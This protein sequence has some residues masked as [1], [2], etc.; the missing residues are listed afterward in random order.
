M[1]RFLIFLLLIVPFVSPIKSEKVFS[2][3]EK[4][5]DEIVLLHEEKSFNINLKKSKSNVHTV[6]WQ[7][8]KFSRKATKQNKAK[9]IQ[10]FFDATCDIEQAFDMVM[11]GIKN[12]VDK[13]ES[14]VNS[15]GVNAKLKLDGDKFKIIKEKNGFLMDKSLLYLK[16]LEKLKNNKE[17]ILEIPTEKTMPSFSECDLK[18]CTNLRASF[19]TNYSKSSPERKNN[20]QKAIASFNGLNI[21]PGECV[22]FNKTT[23]PRNEKNGYQEAKI[24]LGG[25]Y[26]QGFG[27]GVCQAS[28][29]IYNA[30]I[31]AGLDCTARCHS[32]PPSYVGKGLDAMVNLGSSDMTITNNLPLPVYIQAYCTDDEIICNVYGEDLCGYSFVPK[33][34]INETM[35]D[36]GYKN[37]I[38]EKKEFA[39]KV[40]YT[41]ESFVKQKATQGFKTTTY[42]ETLKDG[43]LISK[44]KLRSDFYPP[45]EGI[46]VFGSEQRPAPEI[47]FDDIDEWFRDLI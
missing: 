27:G 46:V 44:T 45:S 35:P 1:K 24:I 22:S 43:K 18:K 31:R 16:I 13:S 5:K 6:I 25:E 19:K 7:E 23:G 40:Y 8:S 37:I 10:M 47:V 34:E 29:T 20:I 33:V 14:E 36:K 21:Y 12:E 2:Y 4:E 9:T 28:T 30:C 11:P 41:D 32:I 15:K 26:I 3:S 42:I 17:L 38:D 39:D